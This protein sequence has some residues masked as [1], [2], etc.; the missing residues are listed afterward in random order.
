MKWRAK[1][2]NDETNITIIGCTSDPA[3]GSQKDFKKMFKHSIYF[4]YPDYTTRRHM[5]RTFIENQANK[6]LI[7]EVNTI[8]EKEEGKPQETLFEQKPRAFYKLPPDFPLSTLA[9]ITEG[10][11]AGSI[12]KAC[13]EVLTDFRRSRLE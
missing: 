7:E 13:E 5:W 8:N 1:W 9:H 12:K 6:I 11:S 4:P 2:L 10:Y 3:R